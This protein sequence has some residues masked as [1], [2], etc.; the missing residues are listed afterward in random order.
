MS[1]IISVEIHKV[2]QERFYRQQVFSKFKLEISYRESDLLICTDKK[3][4]EDLAREILVKHY[5]AVEEYIQK[6]PAFLTSL[7]PLELEEDQKTL[8]IIK[9]MIEVSKLTGIG[10]FASVAGAIALYVGRE[11]LK[12]ADEVIIEN[13]GD[14]FLKINENKRLEVYLG[15]SFELK[16]LT[17]EI[18][19]RDY[20]FGI[21]S[22]SATFGHSLNFGK[23]DLVTIIAR[24]PISADGFATALS[25]RLKKE[26][27]VKDVLEIA[28][29]SDLIEG[30]L[31][32]FEGK[33]YL[34]GD[35]KIEK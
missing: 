22:S 11:I 21:A 14:I 24:D 32:F 20:S 8:P 35:L 15:E 2:Y 3:I 6:N 7:S 10:P 23:A 12:Y 16:N 30:I 33:I 1:W 9:D 17:L 28:K 18:K 27:D 25:N 26:K 29:N 19:K 4:N 34:W 5:Q 13:G 31:I